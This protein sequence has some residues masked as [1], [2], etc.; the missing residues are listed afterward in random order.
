MRAWFAYFYQWLLSDGKGMEQE[1]KYFCK[2]YW[3]CHLNQNYWCSSNNIFIKFTCL[4][5]LVKIVVYTHFFFTLFFFLIFT[6]YNLEWL[7]LAISGRSFV[8]WNSFFLILSFFLQKKRTFWWAAGNCLCK[9]LGRYLQKFY[10][11]FIYLFLFVCCIVTIS[12]RNGRL[13][14]C[15]LVV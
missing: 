4:N 3:L 13:S 12:W 9:R 5:L 2:G 11:V 1:K 8:T 6:I 10:T 7:L 15:Q 14:N